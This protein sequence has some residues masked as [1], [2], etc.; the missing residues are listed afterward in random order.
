ML[1]RAGIVIA[2]GSTTSVID[3][4]V[5]DKHSLFAYKF[6]DLL[7]K[8]TSFMTSTTLFVKLY[9]YHV[10]LDQTPQRYFVRNWGHL[11]GDF[12]FVAK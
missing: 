3:T 10:E 4:A 7:K 9:E 11:D 1:N 5:D 8:N 6:L 12:V 2:S